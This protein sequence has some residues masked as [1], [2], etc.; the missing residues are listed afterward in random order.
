MKLSKE[1]AKKLWWQT[2]PYSEVNVITQTRF[3]DDAVTRTMKYIEIVINPLTFEIVKQNVDKFDESLG[4]DLLVHSADDRWQKFG[5]VT[6]GSPEYPYNI[7]EN[8]EIDAYVEA[9]RKNA[10]KTVIAMHKFVMKLL[11]IDTQK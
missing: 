9:H 4:I 6:M 10:E 7:Y 11:D 2:G 8:S 1:Q 3:L 5:Y